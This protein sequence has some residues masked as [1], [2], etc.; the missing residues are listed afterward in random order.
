MVNKII[1][2]L[3]ITGKQIAQEANGGC[4]IANNVIKYY[5]MLYTCPGDPAAKALLEDAYKK[6]ESKGKEV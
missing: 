5:T 3:K 4:E 2:K 6:W 1:K